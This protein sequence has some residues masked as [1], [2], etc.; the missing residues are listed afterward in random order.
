MQP[1]TV[2]GVLR[3]EPL[4]EDPGD[5]QEQRAPQSRAAGGAG[6][7][8]DPVPVECQRR[9]HHARHPVSWLEALGEEIGLAEHAVQV[10]VEPGQEVART[11]PEAR[12]EDARVPLVVDHGDVR[13]AVLRRKLVQQRPDEC[14][15]ALRLLEPAKLGQARHRGGELGQPRSR[16]QPVAAELELDGIGPASLV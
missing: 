8:H 2:D 11:E 13:R 1:W 16:T 5:D 15:R 10:Q 9:R 3:L 6:R 14:E 4:V 7:E 12:R